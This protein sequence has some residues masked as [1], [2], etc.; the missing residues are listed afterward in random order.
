MQEKPAIVF[1]QETKS[2][3]AVIDSISNKIWARCNSTS[4]DASGASGGLAIL[5]NPQIVSLDN[6]HA[7]HHIIQATFHLIGTNIHGHITNV[8][9]PQSIQQKLEL[10]DTISS[11]NEG[12]HYPL[13]I[14][15]GDFNII[16]TMEE[17]QGGRIRLDSDSN[18][19]KQFLQNNRLMDIPTSNGIFTWSNKRRGIHHITS[20]LDRFL[21]SD[22][23]VHLGGDF[24]ASIIPQGGSDHWPVMLHWSRLGNGGNRPFRFKAFWF[25]NKNFKAVVNDAWTTYKPPEGAKMYQFQQK[26]KNL[27]YA[28]KAWNRN[29]FG[30]IQEQRQQLEQQMK[31]LQQKFILEGR[32]EEQIKQEQEL[33]HQIEERQKQEE[34][35][36]RQ[37]SRISWLKDGEKNTR[38][39]HKSTIQRRMHN[40]ITFVTNQQ[41]ERIETHEEMEKEFTGYFKEILKEPEGNRTEAIRAITQHIPK[42]IN[43]EHNNKLLQPTTL[44]EVEEA[45]AQLKDGKAPGPDGFT[46]NFFHE[47]WDLI[48]AEVWEL[49]E[50]SRSTHWVLPALNSTFI[51]LVPKE[52]ESHK[53][54]KYRPIALCNVIYKLIS[55]VIANRL[56]PLLPLLI[57]PEQ[58]GYVEGR[59]IMDGIILS[60]EVIHSLKLLKKPGMLLKLDLSKAFDKLSWHYIQKMLLAFGFNAT[61]TKWVMNLITSPSFSVLLNGSPSIPFRP[62]RGIRQGDPLSPFIFVLM[63]EGLSRL[64]KSVVSSQAMKGLSLHGRAPQT[65][66]QFVDDTMLFGHPSSKEASALKSLLSLFSDASGTSINAA[67]SQLFFFSTPPSTQR[68]IARILGYPISHLPSKYL[69][70]PL[71]NSA[72]KHAS[73]R[74]LLDKLE[75][76]LS[77][78]TFRALNIAGRLVLIKSVLQA[79]PLYLF[80]ILAAPKWVL[81]AIRN[82]Q[83]NFLWGSTGLNRKWALVKWT[84]ICKPKSEGGLSLRDPLHNNNTMGARVWWNWV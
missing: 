9:F 65:H 25:T 47:F 21:I 76:K 75:S 29:R 48:K 34:I 41:G 17:K 82:L 18:G 11:L 66:Q 58:T 68:H 3:S 64:L 16:K 79:M 45:M 42:I 83:R 61:W 44:K 1:L 20:K 54:E 80:S 51:A 38:F 32:T 55:K 15:E 12:R 39:F 24:T 8:Y 53:P 31:E 36:W 7:T 50:E 37:K 14:G 28:L 26:L 23:A 30:N 63:A 2:S 59:Q 84:D 70:A 60:N 46:A 74:L 49:V 4:V 27:K 56:K 67:K 33:W 40:K 13:W 19:F 78:W 69:G 43:E 10:L 77:T 5:W 35:L 22:N 81:K 71:S 62:T 57:S 52:A 72:I 73:W 6:F